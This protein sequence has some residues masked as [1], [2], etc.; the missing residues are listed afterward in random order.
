MQ[1]AS[2]DSR[3][4]GDRYVVAQNGAKIVEVA[5]FVSHGDQ[6]PVA[7]PGGNTASEDR[8]SLAIGLASPTV[9]EASRLTLLA[10]RPLRS[11]P[12]R[13]TYSK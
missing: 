4:Q 3:Y 9:S 7:V 2:P 8:A 6:P 5:F 12:G 10:L 13:L 1:V 11:R